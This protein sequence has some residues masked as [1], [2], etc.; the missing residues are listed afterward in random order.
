MLIQNDAPIPKAGYPDIGA[1]M[2]ARQLPYKDWYK[3]NI[4]QR[5]HGNSL[6]HLS[7]GLPLIFVQGVFMPRFTTAMAATM[8]VGREFYRFG[9]L[10]KHGPSSRVREVG[11]VA[12]NAAGVFLL[13]SSAFVVLKRQTG[14]FFSRRNFVRRFTMNQYDKK[15]EKVVKDA[16]NAAKGYGLKPKTMLPM[17]PKIMED[18]EE[19]RAIARNALKTPL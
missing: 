16:E 4:Y 2:F 12:L 8:F 14:G 13:L 9:Y 17:H 1:G 18:M 5:I 3:Q 7:W 19:R 11:A 10:D 6:E 15:L